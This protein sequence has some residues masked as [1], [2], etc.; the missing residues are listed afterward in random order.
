M[1]RPAVG[2]RLPEL[3]ILITAL[4]T[5]ASCRQLQTYIPIVSERIVPMQFSLLSFIPFFFTLVFIFFFLKLGCLS[6][7]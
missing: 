7:D 6:G 2:L 1:D 5:V 3:Q 4:G